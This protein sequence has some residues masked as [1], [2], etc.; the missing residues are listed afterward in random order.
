M[1]YDSGL[2]LSFVLKQLQVS[3][4]WHWAS[5]GVISYAHMKRLARLLRISCATVL[6]F[7]STGAF[8]HEVPS[9]KI[10]IVLWFD[11]EDYI[12]PTS[13]DAAKRLA[14]FLTEQGIRATFKVVGEKARTLERRHRTDVI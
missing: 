14:T 6:L 5:S 11:T 9:T 2:A 1:L 8:G 12:L 4:L 13:D 10:Y 7:M 3:L